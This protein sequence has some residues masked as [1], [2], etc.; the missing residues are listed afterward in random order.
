MDH[1]I[2]NPKWTG[3]AMTAC[4][5]KMYFHSEPVKKTKGPLYYD[6]GWIQQEQVTITNIHAHSTGI[7][8]YESRLYY[9]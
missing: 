2:G 3:V 7:S 6:N 4:N 5:W 8:I 9:I 1:K